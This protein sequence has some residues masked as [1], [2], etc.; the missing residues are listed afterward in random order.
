MLNNRPLHI[1]LFT[2]DTNPASIVN[3]YKK[4]VST[5]ITWDFR[6]K[7]NDYE[8]YILEDLYHMAE[9]DCLIRSNSYFS[10][11][12]QLLGSHKI[13]LYPKHA[14]V[15]KDR[16]VIDEVFIL[17]KNSYKQISEEMFF[18]PLLSFCKIKLM[19]NYR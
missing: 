19:K 2:D 4:V 11:A 1:I 8:K 17:K 10:Q 14:L 6:K 12:A 16:I 3:S 7:D 18:I 15:L 9:C 13:V 5:D